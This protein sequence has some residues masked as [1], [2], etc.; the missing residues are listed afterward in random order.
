MRNDPAKRISAISIYLQKGITTES[1][2]FV[3]KLKNE[4]PP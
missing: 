3:K 4:L 1:T 2:D